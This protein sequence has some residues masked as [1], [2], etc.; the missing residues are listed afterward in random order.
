MSGP[1][2]TKTPTLKS[3][4]LPR[5][6]FIDDTGGEQTVAPSETVPEIRGAAE[7][8]GDRIPQG[9]VV[10]LIYRSS[11]ELVTN[12]LACLLAGLRPLVIQYPTK[13]QTRAYW[14][15]SVQNTI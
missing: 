3:T 6:T 7:Y 8:F 10:G 1:E 12:W 5:F 2:T 11:P 15:D 14:T 4:H 9:T 13:K